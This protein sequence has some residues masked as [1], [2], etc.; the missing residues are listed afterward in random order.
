M[1]KKKNQSLILILAR[2]NSKRLKNKNIKKLNSKPLI[3]WTINF[4][5]KINRTNNILVSS[6]SLKIIK[7]AKTLVSSLHGK[8]QIF[9][10]NQ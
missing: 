9:F 6:D 10:Q 4:A 5:K 7:I 8:D 2:K 1:I 3:L